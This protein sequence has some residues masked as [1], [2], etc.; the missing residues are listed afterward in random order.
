MMK[1]PQA[2][3]SQ[4]GSPVTTPFVVK[5]S[6]DGPPS[7]M[8]RGKHTGGAVGLSTVYSVAGLHVHPASPAGGLS[9]ETCASRGEPPPL[10][11]EVSA[12]HAS[13]ARHKRQL[14]P[15]VLP[16]ESV[17]SPMT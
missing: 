3:C 15:T 10:P 1:M 6:Q 2:D 9:D 13:R 11:E 14:H 8:G 5:Q 17:H 16:I 7:Q 4:P 12:T